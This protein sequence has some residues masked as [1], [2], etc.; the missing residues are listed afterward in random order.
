MLIRDGVGII[1]AVLYGPDRRTRLLPSTTRALFAAY[2]PEGIGRDTL[3]L[4]LER[5][6][7]L[8]QVADP[9]AE[10]AELSIVP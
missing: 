9:A 4:H 2:A 5:I 10:V 7:Q 8:V 3:R 6:A 1:S